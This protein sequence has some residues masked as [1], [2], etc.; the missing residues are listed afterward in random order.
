VGPGR[1]LEEEIVADAGAAD[2]TRDM[3][4]VEGKVAWAAV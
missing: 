4:V 1:L 3:V 2:S